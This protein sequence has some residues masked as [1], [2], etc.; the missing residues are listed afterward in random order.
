MS[1]TEASARSASGAAAT[2][3]ATGAAATARGAEAPHGA[4]QLLLDDVRKRFGG[5]HA[6][7][8]ARLALTRPGV[9]HGLIGANGSGKSTLLGVLSGQQRPDAGRIVLDG[10]EIALTSPLAALRHGIA[11]VSQETALAPDLSIAENVFLGGRLVRR[12][13]RGIDW[14]ASNARAAE[15]LA[16]L[17]LDEDPATPVGRLRPDRQQMVEIARALSQEA[18]ILILD[19]PTSSLGDDEVQALFAAVRRLR[20]RGVSTIFVSHR[21][22]ELLALADELTVLRDGETVAAGPIADFDADRIVEAMVGPAVAERAR[23]RSGAATRPAAATA[24]STTTTTA[25]VPAL[26]LRGVGA[27]GLLR[28]VDLDVAAG[29]VV[30]L[31]GV[32]GAGRSELLEAIF[33]ALPASGTVELHG[34]A[35]R[36]RDP[37]AAIAAGVGYLPPDRKHQGL[38]L[39]RSVAD[40][41]AM[42]ATRDAGR[43]RAPGGA[44]ER[45][46]VGEAIATLRIVA[47]S[48]AAPV[49]TLSGGNQ[50]KVALGRW[51]A[52]R[53]RVL[54]LDEPTRGVDVA[55]KA[56][57]H[58]LL[59]AAAADGAALLVSSSETEELLALCDRI[60]VLARGEVVASLTAEEASEEA[61]ARFAGGHA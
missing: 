9:V 32:V 23:A 51:I 48:P 60:V 38:V 26:R 28:E 5:V 35:L 56:E 55:A 10:A 42:V 40:N 19:E 14:R 50:Q 15:L 46:L 43:L 20:A 45:A 17:G 6:L 49:S 34:S 44:A 12:R 58:R 36:A 57:I 29:E 18:R 3:A 25:S 4:P 8:G 53:S 11:M 59:R 21:L 22:P 54:L 31:A 2:G 30:G 33:G 37:R 41:L 24:G 13:V 1:A 52:A 16:S 47:A 7:R 27:P 39:Q 61:V